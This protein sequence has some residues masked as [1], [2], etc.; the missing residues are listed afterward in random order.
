[1]DP[2]NIF[3]ARIGRRVDIENLSSFYNR[4]LQSD[5]LPGM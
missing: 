3:L 4:L 2:A 5:N 1:M